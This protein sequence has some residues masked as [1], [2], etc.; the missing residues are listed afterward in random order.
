MQSLHLQDDS[1]D[2]S[3]FDESV[4]ESGDDVYCE[5]DASSTS[6]YD[7]DGDNIDQAYYLPPE[8]DQL[9]I[10]CDKDFLDHEND[11]IDSTLI[12]SVDMDTS[13][14]EGL[15]SIECNIPSMSYEQPDL[16]EG[17]DP[18]TRLLLAGYEN[19]KVADVDE[20]LSLV[21]EKKFICSMSSMRELFAFCVDIDCKMPLTDVKESFVGCVLEIRWKCK[22]G[23]CGEWKSSKMV[24]KLYV[25][26]LLT[27]AALLFT[28]N[29]YTK[30]AYFP[31]VFRWHSL[32][33]HLSTSTKSCT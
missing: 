6:S 33:R 5:S 2:E 30:L 3:V 32:A 13:S 17:N 9:N 24:K 14:T 25:N 8:F 19:C 11:G 23:H 22:V 29:N 26:N 31:N 27:A 1:N 12:E 28:G 7:D 15:G 20:E 4:D 21:N 10:S 16:V 18:L